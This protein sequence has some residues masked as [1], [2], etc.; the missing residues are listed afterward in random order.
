MG[1][2]Q[3]N[4][5]GAGAGKMKKKST[6]ETLQR[7]ETA[8]RRSPARLRATGGPNQRHQVIDSLCRA[9]LGVHARI[10]QGKM[11]TLD[12]QHD[13]KKKIP[14]LKQRQNKIQN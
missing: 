2:F 5:R 12:E 14:D 10:N 8:V 6:L 4:G 11:R 13:G 1:G 7:T 9:L 3:S